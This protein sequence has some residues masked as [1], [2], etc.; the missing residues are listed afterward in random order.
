MA[1][2]SS[3]AVSLIFPFTLTY[4]LIYSL[5]SSWERQE[6]DIG[7]IG[8]A[9][10]YIPPISTYIFRVVFTGENYLAYRVLYIGV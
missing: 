8:N 10:C 2:L 4:S 7:V 9:A 1:I 5:T 3:R 6:K